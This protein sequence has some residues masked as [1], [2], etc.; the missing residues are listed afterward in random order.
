M[1]CGDGPGLVNASQPEVQHFRVAVAAHHHVL[2]LDV[3]MDDAGG[4]GGG[5]RR[6]DLAADVDHRRQRVLPLHLR[7]QRHPV[8]ELLD[9]VVAAVVGL[10]DVVDDHDV[11][12]IEG[13]GRACLAEEP[14]DGEGAVPG[15]SRISLTA[16]GR[17][18]RVST[19]R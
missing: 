13:G 16:T 12:V 4:V 18:S 10:A 11:G 7:A 1:R 17:W 9:D 14:A 5:K 19:A 15:L 2:G 8:D 3:A 6:R